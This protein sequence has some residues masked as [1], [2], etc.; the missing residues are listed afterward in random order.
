MCQDSTSG[1]ILIYLYDSQIFCTIHLPQTYTIVLCLCAVSV[2]HDTLV[3]L[4]KPVSFP[5]LIVC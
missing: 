3:G 5:S 4:L 2:R 1:Y